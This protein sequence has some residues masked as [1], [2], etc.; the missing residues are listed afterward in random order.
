M[1]R[2]DAATLADRLRDERGHRV[3]FVSHCLL[4]ENTRYLGGAFRPAAVSELVDALVGQGIG[5]C[6]MPCPEQ[7]AW[8]GVLKRRMLRAYGSHPSLTYR[9]RRPLLWLFLLHTRTIYRRLAR[10]IANQITDYQS[11]GVTVVAVIGVSASPSCG[12]RTTLYYS[13]GSRNLL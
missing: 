9:L 1:T 8:G 7:Y 4:N 12:V 5:L 2:P 3:A 6:Q 10:E 11:S 13:C